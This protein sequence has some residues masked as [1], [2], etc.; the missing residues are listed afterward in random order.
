MKILYLDPILGISGD[1][2][3]SAL[4][5]AGCPFPVLMDLHGQLPEGPDEGP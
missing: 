5:D 3:I 4:I 1:M 2:T